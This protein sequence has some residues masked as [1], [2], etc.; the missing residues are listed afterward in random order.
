MDSV[1]VLM[2]TY[3]GENYLQEQVDSILGQVGVEVYLIVRD[4]GSKDRTKE[5]LNS[6]RFLENVEIID[7][8]NIGAS[9]SFFELIQVAKFADYYAFADQDDVWD[10][11]KLS[12]A[13]NKVKNYSNAPCVYSSN[14]RLVDKYLNLIKKENDNPLTTLESALIKN[15]CTGC[16]VV[17]NNELMKELKYYQPEYAVMHDWWVNIVA[18]SLGGKSI[19]D[20]EAHMNYR[21]HGK[22]VSGAELSYLNK[23]INRALKF[24]NV[25]YRRDIMAK[26]ILRNYE[27]R[28]SPRNK[29]ILQC[30]VDNS[31][32]MI[33]KSNFRSKEMIDTFLFRV[34]VIFRR[35]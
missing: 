33:F 7:G 17:F 8:S 5:I 11:D 14:T 4:D 6:Y 26:E 18:L 23:C 31:L 16:T 21:Q 13:V 28:I 15:Y 30:F 25:R 27:E 19:Y 34:C 29:E 9:R 12:I 10:S 35:I 24:K 3:N 1:V 22:N 20:I 2:S 32:K